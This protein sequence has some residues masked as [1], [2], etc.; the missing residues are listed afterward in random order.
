MG[1]VEPDNAIGHGCRRKARLAGDLAGQRG[2]GGHALDQ[3]V[4]GRTAGIGALLAK[5]VQ[6]GIDQP[7]IAREQIV[8]A[9]F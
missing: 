5:A 2:Q 1:G 6:A 7:R 8:G 9:E 3:I 4:I